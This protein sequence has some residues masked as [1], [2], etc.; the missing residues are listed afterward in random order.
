[1][2]TLPFTPAM[3]QFFGV[4]QE[5][6]VLITGLSDDSGKVVDRGPAAQAG[7]KPEDVVVEFDGKK[8][9]SVQDLR[10][11][12]ANTP[13]GRKAKVKVV[14]Y[15]VEKEL[16]VAVAERKLEDQER[17]KGT[18]SFEEKEEQPKPEIGLRFDTVPAR[19]AQELNISGG[20]IVEEVKPGSLAD[21]A[22][23]ASPDQGWETDIIVAANGK[24]INAAQDLFN[25]IKSLRS[26]ETAVVKF[27]RVRRNPGASSPP[28][29]YYTSIMKP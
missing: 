29:T 14:R 13:P 19:L 21:E 1:M 3:A 17:E 22:G 9:L 12:V 25:L 18:F 26:G 6:G 15:G 7:M 5:S 2:N 23:F 4:K 28:A 11:A 20:A 27:L 24:P 8:I 10:L 16:E